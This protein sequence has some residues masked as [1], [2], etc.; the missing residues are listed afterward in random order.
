MRP[1][2]TRMDRRTFH[3]RL[4]LGRGGFG[5]VYLAD[6][7]SPGGL[8]SEVAVKVLLESID[9]RSQAVQR[10]RD[11]ARLLAALRHPAIPK[12]HD[13]VLIQGRVALVAEYVEGA[14]LEECILTDPPISPRALIDLVGQ[15]SDAL[16]AAYSSVGPDGSALHL[17]HRDIKP[18]N[19]RVGIRGDVKLLDF[20]I[21]TAKHSDREAK[22]QTNAVIGSFPYMAP[23]RFDDQA[24]PRPESD[25]FAL[26]CVLYEGITGQRLFGDLGMKSL[27]TMA[28]EQEKHA[29]W[30]MPRLDALK[31]LPPDL[32]NLL[33]HMLAYDADERVGADELM[34][35]CEALAPSLPGSSLRV[36]ARKHDWPE[37]H[38]HGGPFA[39]QTVSESAFSLSRSRGD[40]AA[41]DDEAPV[42]APP[43]AAPRANWTKMSSSDELKGSP[44]VGVTRFDPAP[45]TPAPSDSGGTHFERN[46]PRP[47]AAQ[48]SNQTHFEQNAPP[49]VASKAPTP[50]PPSLAPPVAPE[51]PSQKSKGLMLAGLGAAVL[52]LGAVGIVGVGTLGWS[53]SGQDTLEEV[54]AAI[55]KVDEPDVIEP[56]LDPPPGLDALPLVPSTPD[57]G[58]VEPVL[59]VLPTPTV[60]EDAVAVVVAPTPASASLETCGE[61]SKLEMAASSGALSH[62][63]VACLDGL[64]RDDGVAQTLQDKAGRM[65]L[66]HDSVTCSSGGGCAAYERDQRYFFAE[67]TQSDPDMTLAFASHLYKKGGTVAT[68]DEAVAWT[69]RALERRS[70]WKRS[71]FVNNVEIAYR[72]RARSSYQAWMMVL[73]KDGTDAAARRRA[74]T[75]EYAAE[76]S[77]YLVRL[78]RDKTAAFDLCV[79][80]AGATEICE[81]R[82]SDET[83]TIQILIGSVPMGATAFL[84]GKEV[85]RTPARVDVPIGT[86]ELKLEHEGSTS[87]Q[88]VLIGDTLPV[89]H[90][91]NIEEDEWSSAF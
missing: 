20:G 48:P 87:T 91:W 5:E 73:E 9:P 13:L 7:T 84:D 71:A 36:W 49:V 2:D 52:A 12:V 45:R 15:V 29:D 63:Q 10:L 54:D 76:W 75:V 69:D 25:V 78:G 1:A 66:V 90:I 4:C 86:H 32:L 21:A 62:A 31:Q 30:V 50:P 40:V 58:S 80:A 65:V 17:V 88:S 16:D 83:R 23:E 39:G 42:A 77:D 85:G 41:D 35:A 28:F 67:V 55:V 51:P 3:F 82:L 68:L 27:Y 70:V 57:E 72:I 89:K 6:M 64:M 14:D 11:E 74:M 22:T 47:P 81:K 19:I 33:H 43:P 60:A 79:S 26:G 18:A 24:G 37:P 59:A 56:V 8:R 44:P 38:D 61:Q 46:A 53:L 34:T